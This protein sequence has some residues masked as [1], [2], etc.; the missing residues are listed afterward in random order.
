MIYE[1]FRLRDHFANIPGDYDV[2]LTAYCPDNSPEIDKSR[3][4][5]TILICPGGG[6]EFTSDREAEPV[7]LRLLPLGY[8]AFVLRYGVKAAKYPEALLEAAA[9]V[10]FI[11][12]NAEKFNA[13]ANKIAVCGFSAGAHL[14]ASLGVF[15]KE[16][17]IAKT[18]GILEEKNKPNALILCYP[19]ITSGEF[20]HKGSFKALIGNN[21]PELL[22]KMSLEKQVNKDVPPTF[23]WHT[24]DDNTVPVENSLLFAKALK[25]Y[26]VPFELHIYPH[27]CHGLSLCSDETSAAPEL[28]NPHCASWLPLCNKWLKL[29]FNK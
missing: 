15:W 5:P 29:V 21:N 22:E 7:A 2:T 10:A 28:I 4:R 23:L 17:F 14:A 25:A 13:D 16:P 20:A 12:N 3:K 11:R 8:N 18:L 9:A 6:Y 26:N 19:V 1:T 24:F 27:G